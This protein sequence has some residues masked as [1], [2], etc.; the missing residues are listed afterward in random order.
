[1][2]LLC[3][4]FDSSSPRIERGS[5][6]VLLSNFKTLSFKFKTSEMPKNPDI[7][8]ILQNTCKQKPLALLTKVWSHKMFGLRIIF[9][10]MTYDI[11]VSVY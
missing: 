7:Y 5:R 1:M 3:Y 10:R 11:P 8:S 2:L 6:D 4:M 9:A